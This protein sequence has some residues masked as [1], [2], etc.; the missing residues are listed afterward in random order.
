MTGVSLPG[1]RGAGWADWG[2]KEP[3]EMI[4][5]IRRY[6]K[7]Q[8]EWAQK[9][10]EADDADFRVDT[11]LGPHAQRNREVLQDGRPTPSTPLP[12]GSIER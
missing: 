6:A 1:V 10:L 4:A 7:S 8:I 9:V 2:R 11:Y 5:A 12:S 3:S